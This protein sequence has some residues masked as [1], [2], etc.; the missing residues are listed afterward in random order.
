MQGS[1]LPMHSRLASAVYVKVFST[2][3]SEARG[4]PLSSRKGIHCVHHC[5]G[6]ACSHNHCKH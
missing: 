2:S 1:M 5:T 3:M 6:T 4:V